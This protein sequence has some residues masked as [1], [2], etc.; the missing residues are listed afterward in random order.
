MLVPRRQFARCGG[1]VSLIE[2]PEL[3]RRLAENGRR[4]AE[5][6]VFGG[7]DGRPD[8]SGV[9]AGDL[10]PPRSATRDEASVAARSMVGSRSGDAK[11]YLRLCRPAP[12]ERMDGR[13]L[14][15]TMREHWLCALTFPK[16]SEAFILN[17]LLA[18]KLR[19]SGCGS[20][21]YGKRPMSPDIRSWRG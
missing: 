5:S 19:A 14:E 20:P 18:W 21:H 6:E 2:Q 3:A 13:M 1:I 16:L 4:L 15:G 10:A 11:V 8:G 9:R 12:A 17:E 7:T